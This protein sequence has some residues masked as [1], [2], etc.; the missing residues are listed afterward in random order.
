[1]TTV[2]LGGSRHVSVLGAEVA[3]RVER[4]IAQGLDVVVGDAAGADR[5]FQA[6]LAKVGYSKVIV[7]H[8][9]ARCRN[10]VGE[11]PTR[12]IATDAKAG[13]AKFYSAKDKVM[14]EAAEFGL[15]LWD[16]A[17][18]GTPLNVWR[19]LRR[20]KKAV[21]FITSSQRFL[22]IREPSDW[23]TLLEAARTETR[24]EVTRRIEDE[25]R[26]EP[27]GGSESQLELDGLG[28]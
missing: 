25:R 14:A 28:R 20:R 24:T 21:V 12:S 7:F 6:H 1:M 18:A 9:G 19:L 13:T 23:E 8:S 27:R 4:I 15:M 5:A 17:S 16:G 11:W 22:E 10:N 3:Q 26:D 2:F